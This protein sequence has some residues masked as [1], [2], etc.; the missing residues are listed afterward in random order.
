MVDEL[1]TSEDCIIFRNS[2]FYLNVMIILLVVLN[3]V[4]VF[5]LLPVDHT[6]FKALVRNGLFVHMTPVCTYDLDPCGLFVHMTP[7]V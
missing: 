7:V 6:F 4:C 3:T 1:I 5:R 2:F